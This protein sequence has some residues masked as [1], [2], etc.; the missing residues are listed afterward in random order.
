MRPSP[1][2]L[3][4]SFPDPRDFARAVREREGDFAFDAAA[5]V[6]LG[7]AYF[8]FH[9]DASA[10]RD[11]QAVQI[12]YALVRACA[13]ERMIA[14]LE[15]EGRAFYRAALGQ[16]ARIRELIAARLD[17]AAAGEPPSA[18]L[19]AELEAVGA[20][21]DAIRA[22]IELIPKG[23]IKERFVGGISLLTNGLYLVRTWLRRLTSPEAGG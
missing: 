14:G 16:P 13:V 23:M 18:R 5:M 12:G 17:L 2:D 3:F 7:R 8:E 1:A 20:A 4:R 15:P 10:D 19:R 6:E 21:L 11:L 22:E 9:P